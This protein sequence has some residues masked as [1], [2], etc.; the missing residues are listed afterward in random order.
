MD[1]A[2]CAEK[3]LR[4]FVTYCVYLSEIAL[5]MRSLVDETAATE[6]LD[7][8]YKTLEQGVVRA[9]FYISVVTQTAV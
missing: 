8:V 1:K 6:Y 3:K 5:V 9:T 2:S 7:I 4:I